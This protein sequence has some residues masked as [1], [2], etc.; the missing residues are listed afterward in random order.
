MMDEP[1]MTPA[2]RADT[3]PAD[4]VRAEPRR[5]VAIVPHTHWDREWY[6][7]FQTF[8]LRLVDLLDEFVPRLEADPSYAHFLLDGQMAVV[9]DY[10]A[11]RPEAGA[12]LRRLAGSG[13]LSVGPWYILMDEFLVSGETIVRNLQLGL[14]RAAAFGGAMPVG[15]LPDMFGHIAQMPQ[16]LHQAGFDHAVVWR[17]VPEAVDRSG[18]WWSA[19]D[20]STVRAEYL[21]VG[22]GNGAAV[23][24][25]AKAFVRRVAAHEAE[26]GA[27][28]VDPGSPILWMNG[29][30]HQ[31]P[32]P[33]L[34]RV[35]SEANELQHDY[36]FAIM[37]LARYLAAAP[38]EGLPGWRGELRSGARANLLM[39]VGSNRVDVKQAA[40]R[41]ERALE[42]EAEPLCT[43]WMPADL[44]PKALL[45]LAWLE[46][47]RNSAHDSIC[48]CS[49]DEVGLAV[50]HRYGEATAIADGLRRRAAKLAGAVVPANGP[51]ALNPSPRARGGVI[52]LTL[53]GD[54]AVAGAQLIQAT[55]A[56]AVEVTG[57]GRELPMLLG[58]LIDDG[59]VSDRAM[60][61]VEVNASE[62]R[63]DVV[64]RTG[65]GHRRAWRVASAMAELWAQAGA[66]PGVPVHVRIERAPSQRVAVHLASVP[67]YGWAA[68]SP[69]PLGVDPVEVHD[70]RGVVRMSNGLAHMTVEPGTGTF[71]LNG[72]TG[73]DRLVDD[74]DDGDTYNWCPPDS[75]VVVD[76]P[77]AVEIAVV[78]RGPVRSRIHV[79]RTYGWPAR[80]DHGKRVGK[81][82]VE[83]QTAL[84]L[85]AGEDLVRITTTFDNRARDHR[86]R[87]W[88]PLPVPARTSTAECAFAVVERGLEAEGGPHEP[89]LATYPSRRFVSA[90]GLT[91]LHE[92][93]LEYELA[94]GGRA[95][96]V[97]LVRSTGML[98]RN[99]MTSRPNPAGPALALEG[100]QVQGHLSLRYA[101]HVGHADPYALADQAWVPLELTYGASGAG[102]ASSGSLLAVNGAEVS[103]L[104]RVGG[105]IELRVFNPSPRQTTVVIDGRRGW[106]VDLRGAPV[107]PFEQSFPLRP[108]GMAT[109]RLSE[110]ES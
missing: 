81:E 39:G 78:E 87:A 28:L 40:A 91:V 10:L 9:D 80:V 97:T 58:R 32:Q 96:A 34:G 30:D 23:P 64:L 76:R 38:T 95:L 16:L 26:L 99:H 49:A 83:V 101:V 22:Y 61:S 106:L 60:R 52:E 103:S 42:R 86:L 24:D 8:R 18:F 90:G 88:F 85:R 6:S 69:G 46:V 109:A 4:T 27:F 29:T 35:V 21:R 53:P 92:G 25:D 15:Y 48:A 71:S 94:D 11:V 51:I 37:S 89:G 74:G 59:L 41:A 44:W 14:E 36:R 7:A 68:W 13:R 31:T 63:V 108:W 73:L 17:G 75:D 43:L 102:A 57:L 50:L 65:D 3:V 66:H 47:I 45:D 33:W 77:D 55:P 98:S 82:R 70:G 1:A 104:R 20:G 79:T 107:D 84:E 105:A 67:G 62:N 93:L 5:T 2:E 100:S 110:A 54:Q 72:C 56:A 12:A 19:P